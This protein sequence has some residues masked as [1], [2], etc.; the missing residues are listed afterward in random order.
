MI[1]VE[2]LNEMIQN[3]SS[4][5]VCAGHPEER[6]LDVCKSRKDQIKN[7]SGDVVAFRDDCPVPLHGELYSSTIRSPNCEL[8]FNDIKCGT[9]KHYRSVL[10][11]IHN[12]SR[13]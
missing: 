4:M 3:I 11:S 8:L 7:P 5:N 6:F 2:K 1:T 12:R 10:R 9:C 13:Q